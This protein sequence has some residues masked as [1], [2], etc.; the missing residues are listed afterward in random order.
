MRTIAAAVVVLLLGAPPPTAEEI[1]ARLNTY[2]TE[3]EPK[4]SELIA[5]EHLLQRD[6]PRQEGRPG[7]EAFLKRTL[8][9]EVAFIALPGD[10]GWLGFR[11]VLQLD[12]KPVED[13][14]G[15]LNAVL[16]S[17][18]HDDYAKA[19]AMLT[20]S[21]RFNLGTPRTIN[22]PNLPLEVLHPRH[23]ERFTMRIAGSERIAGRQTIKLVLVESVTPTIIRAF[24]GSQMRSIVTAFVEPETGRL[25][26]ADVVTRDP[27]P[28]RVVFDHVVSVTFQENRTLGLLVPAK[29]REDFFAG[30][31]RKAWGDATYVDYRRF[32]TSARI[33]PQ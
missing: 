23:A 5:D 24:D 33:V 1:R 9:S 13:T 19:R 15:S 14:L 22:L 26:R 10:A 11:R 8:K 7:S 25:W 31:D 30:H 32:Q 6:V 27:R 4:L 28:A 3:Y 16:T 21:A 2:L 20:D 18:S 12:D 17:G 29:M